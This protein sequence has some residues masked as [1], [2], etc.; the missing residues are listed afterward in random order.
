[1]III[2]GDLVVI[3]RIKRFKPSRISVEMATL[4]H[5]MDMD[6]YRQ[7]FI[8]SSYNPSDPMWEDTM[9]VDIETSIP[10]WF[11][12]YTD[13][14]KVKILKLPIPDDQSTDETIW[15]KF[16]GVLTEK[17]RQDRLESLDI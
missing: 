5:F 11:D 4:V 3:N 12:Q 13:E 6:R 10:L 1:M 15:D 9:K 8:G 14:E 2:K 17:F 7:L 16:I